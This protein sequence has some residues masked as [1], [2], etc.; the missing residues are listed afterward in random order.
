MQPRIYTIVFALYKVLKNQ[1]IFGTKFEF[2]INT[3]QIKS[4]IIKVSNVNNVTINSST[5]NVFS[6][7]TFYKLFK[8]GIQ[9]MNFIYSQTKQF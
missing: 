6:G 5:E 8:N 2:M 1:K 4:N 9:K 7:Y 3:M